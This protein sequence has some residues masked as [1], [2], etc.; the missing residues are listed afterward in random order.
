MTHDYDDISE[1]LYREDAELANFPYLVETVARLMVV[2]RALVTA[3][4]QLDANPQRYADICELLDGRV[5]NLVENAAKADIESPKPQPGLEESFEEWTG[6]AAAI[7]VGKTQKGSLCTKRASFSKEGQPYCR[8]HYPYPEGYKEARQNEREQW[9]KERQNR[10]FLLDEYKRLQKS[11]RGLNG[12]N[13]LLESTMDRLGITGAHV[14]GPKVRKGICET[15][16]IDGLTFYLEEATY[17]VPSYWL[18]RESLGSLSILQD[19]ADKGWRVVELDSNSGGFR[20][21]AGK[22]LSSRQHAIRYTHLH[23]MFY[24][25]RRRRDLSWYNSA[26]HELV[27]KGCSLISPEPL[28]NL[29][30]VDIQE[31][32]W[33]VFENRRGGLEYD[34]RYSGFSEAEA[35]WHYDAEADENSAMVLLTDPS[36][37]LIDHRGESKRLW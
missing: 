22:F 3:L 4:L 12:M 34:C 20:S 8:A 32:G 21:G 15:V 14:E 23:S 33:H 6:D 30:G 18:S 25:V 27:E 1:R 5:R 16:Y 37:Q 29:C 24:R 9:G 26:V 11:A 17:P 19:Y 36:N 28:Q 13:H 35:R 31:P 2:N 7:C 10:E